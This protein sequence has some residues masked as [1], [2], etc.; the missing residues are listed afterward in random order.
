MP[1]TKIVTRIPDDI[2]T[3]LLQPAQ[4]HGSSIGAEISRSCRE[5]ME[6]ERR[7]RPGYKPDTAAAE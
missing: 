6:R 5:R 3:W 1:S 4:H 2:K 7:D